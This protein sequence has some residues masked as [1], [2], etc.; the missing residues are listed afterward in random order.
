[1]KCIEKGLLGINLRL[2]N[3][4]I[5]LIQMVRYDNKIYSCMTLHKKEQQKPIL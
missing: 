4:S 3:I 1:M 5:A 2:Q